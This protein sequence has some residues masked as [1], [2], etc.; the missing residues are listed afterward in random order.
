MTLFQRRMRQL[1]TG[2]DPIDIAPSHQNHAGGDG[3][4]SPQPKQIQD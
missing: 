2:M 1:L 4:L 3:F